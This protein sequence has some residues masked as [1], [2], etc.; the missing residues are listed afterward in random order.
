MH[1]L[2][3]LTFQ[4]H[5]LAGRRRAQ[6]VGTT[7]KRVIHNSQ[8]LK[9]CAK[10]TVCLYVSCYLSSLATLQRSHYTI[11]QFGFQCLEF[12][13]DLTQLS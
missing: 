9:P 8:G 7:I 11:E 4:L 2:D 1:S 3:A 6:F 5:D 10:S 12:E 13:R